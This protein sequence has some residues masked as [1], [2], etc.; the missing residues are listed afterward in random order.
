MVQTRRKGSNFKSNARVK[1]VKNRENVYD[2]LDF[3]NYSV[4]LTYMQHNIISVQPVL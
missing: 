2:I 1:S 3:S 4:A